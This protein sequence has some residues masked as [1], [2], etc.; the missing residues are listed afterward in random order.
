MKLQYLGTGAAEGI[1]AVFCNCPTCQKAWQE[2]GKNIRSRSQAILNDKIL[3]DFPPDSF[4]HMM[5]N[6]TPLATFKTMVVT[7][8]HQDHWYPEELRFKFPP[9][10]H[11][12]QNLD[13]YGNPSVWEKYKNA[14]IPDNTPYINFHVIEPYEPFFIEGIK[15]TALIANHDKR[16][17]CFIYLFEEGAEKVLYA[18]DTGFLPENSYAALQGKPLDIISM[19]CTMGKQSEGTNHMGFPD[20][21][22]FVEKLSSLGC[23]HDK[24]KC[25]MNHFSHNGGLLHEDLEK[26]AKQKGFFVAYDGFVIKTQKEEQ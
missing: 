19:D 4:L 26:L 5:M 16:E 1:P 2:K 6:D 21:I 20:D 18:H 24:T 17:N 14:G 25:V 8:S 10:S 22:T 15:T 3:I 11:S 13:I 9:Y 12:S 7:H 23:V